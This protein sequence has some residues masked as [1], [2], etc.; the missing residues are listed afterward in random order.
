MTHRLYPRL[1]WQ[2]ITKNKRL[3]LP[4]L[5]TCVGMVMMTYILLSLAS[6]PILQ[7]FPGGDPMPMILGMGSFV[8]A[9]FAVLFLFYT[10]SF[11]IRRRNRE[12]GLYNILGMGKG[13]LA[14]VLAWETVIMALISIAGGEV[15]GIA[16]GKLFE[17]L[18]V[19]IVDGTVQM[20]FTVSVPAT[21]MT[22]ILYLAIFAL[23]F[24]RSLVTV[25]KTNAAA[26]LR[27]EACGEKPPKANWVFG[28]AGFLIL[29]AAYYIAVTIKQPLTALAVFFIAVLMVIVATYLIFISGSVVLCRALQK[30]KRYYYQKNHFIS[31]SSMAYRMKRNGAGLAS[32]CILATMVLVMLS[33][34]TCLYFGKEDALRT[35]YPSDLSVELRFTKDEG[36]MDEANIA[37]ARGMIE[38]VIKQDGL[39]VQGQFDIRSAWFSGL[40]TGNT[41]TRAQESTL[42]D[43]ERA[44]DLTVLPLED[45]TRMTGER[46]TLEPGEAYLCSPRMAYTQPDIRIGELTYQIK[47]QLPSFGGFG[48]DSANITTTIYLIVPDFDAAV[49][50]LRTQNTRYP[51]VVSWQYSFDSGSPDEAQIAFLRDMMGTFADNREGLVYASYT[52]ESIAS[53]REDFV[54]TYGSLFFLAILLSI[55]FLA[56]AVLILYYK[57]ISEGYE[58]QA[59]FEIMQRVGMT[60]TD[61]RKSINSQLLLVFFLPLLFAGLHL[62]FAF[63]FVHKML[64]LFNLTNLKL[65]IGTTVV[66]FAIYA[67]FYTLVY[68]ITSNSYYSIVAGAKEDAA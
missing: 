2:G 34:T 63:P 48:A 20:Q 42:M 11:L 35:R 32:I 45:Y 31:V 41:F 7:T 15:L 54:G 68:R 47:G 38:D 33:S 39:D 29:G 49:N 13:N 26:L 1:A 60:K 8:M 24:L 19:N 16:L 36:G 10:N 23:L 62:G 66:T 57:Q 46:L 3:Y 67:V 40:L 21:T 4:F 44:V 27:S 43:Y 6:S 9:A 17:L 56:A 59:R 30:N 58:D 64:V 52:V 18:L 25:C 53:N 51:V 14:K 61:I 50:A 65:L 12:F 28:L 55:V 5:L 22:T 37:I